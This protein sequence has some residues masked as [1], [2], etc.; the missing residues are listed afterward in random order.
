MSWV[1]PVVKLISLFIFAIPLACM[2]QKTADELLLTTADSL[3]VE[4]Q[5]ESAMS[6][7]DSVLHK[8]N[9]RSLLAHATLIKSRILE[10]NDLNVAAL[11][12]AL[13]ALKTSEELK[14]YPIQCG[15]HITIELIH[16]KAEDLEQAEHHLKLA[17]NL[18][19][20]HN[21]PE[22]VSHFYVRASSLLRFTQNNLDSA[23][24]CAEL[25]LIHA[26]QQ[27]QYWHETDAHM[28][29]ALFCKREQK[30]DCAQM[31]YEKTL[32][33]FLG[34]N[35]Y[36]GAGLMLTN[37][38]NIQILKGD[39]ETA[40]VMADSAFNIYSNHC[41]AVPFSFYRK[42]V[43][44]FVALGMTDSAF[45]ASRKEL[46]GYKIHIHE[47][48][49]R[50]ISRM[51]M[52]F[53]KQK[54][55]VELSHQII[56]NEKQE[57]SLD[58][59]AVLCVIIAL[60]LVALILVNNKL[61]VRGR[62]MVEQEELLRQSLHR[63]SVLL[64]ELQ[65]RVRNNL[66]VIIALIDTQRET[67]PGKSID[68]ITDDSTRRIQAMSF[69]HEK[70]YLSKELDKVNLAAYLEEIAH[71]IKGSFS[72]TSTE[73]RIDIECEALYASIDQA[74]PFGLILVEL[75]SNSFKHA[76]QGRATGV[77]SIY[78]IDIEGTRCQ[79]DYSDNGTGYKLEKKHPGL[80]T[81][82]IQG[83]LRQLKGQ[84]VADGSDGY[85]ARITF[86]L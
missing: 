54:K 30:F 3:L 73:V 71:L 17:K 39:F 85:T 57:Q 76:F 21:I 36:A 24:E 37:L 50:E 20:Q 46:E 7:V 43:E 82:I 52:L 34:R 86:K 26:K 5:Y 72:G 70:V 22:E 81:E 35:E 15:A 1:P 68:E 28:M 47:L 29:L 18:I 2:G 44:L 78:V 33:R 66:Q 38:V 79:F 67:E 41:P 6:I 49:G 77:V 25:A 32:D 53:E 63:Q 84:M 58:R 14:L 80:G 64:K 4:F 23:K 60:S 59:I 75:L 27:S 16:E 62:T 11:D 31:H 10:K 51:A 48:K 74:I 19:E 40:R 9:D 65:H 69:L 61:R 8:T 12:F 83:L 56:V 45:V 13:R 55:E 42:Q